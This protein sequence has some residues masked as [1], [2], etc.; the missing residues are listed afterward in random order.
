MR[1]RF[2]RSYVTR[3]RRVRRANLGVELRA[4]VRSRSIL[5][6]NPLSS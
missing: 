6:F 2:G 1:W 4:F 3:Q 5:K